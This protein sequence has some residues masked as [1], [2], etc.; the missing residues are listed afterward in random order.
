MIFCTKIVLTRF[1]VVCDISHEEVK[2]FSGAS[3]P[4]GS[5]G[6]PGIPGVAGPIGNTGATGITGPPGNTGN[7]DVILRPKLMSMRIYSVCQH[8][9]LEEYC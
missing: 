1:I 6:S 2:L 9:A 5:A 8:I 7:A 3:G 4:S